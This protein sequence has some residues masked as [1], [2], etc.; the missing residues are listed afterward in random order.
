MTDNCHKGVMHECAKF[1][2]AI[3]AGPFLFCKY[4]S[5]CV[6]KSQTRRPNV[7]IMHEFDFPSMSFQI[8]QMKV[9]RTDF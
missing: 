8:W 1:G 7:G 6:E 2:L 9:A 4:F 3:S 5:I